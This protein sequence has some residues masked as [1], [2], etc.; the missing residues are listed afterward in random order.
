[1]RSLNNKI[2]AVALAS[3]LIVIVSSVYFIRQ[4]DGI[5]T[6]LSLPETAESETSA[7]TS[8]I[9][10]PVSTSP[11]QY[12]QRLQIG[13]I[14]SASLLM[15]TWIMGA[16]WIIR[17]FR[18]SLQNPENIVAQLVQGNTS[19]KVTTR[20][21]EFA[22]VVTGLAR[23][24]ENLKRSSDFAR[25]I[26]EGNFD[27]QFQPVS[28]LDILGN[29]LLQ[30]REKLKNIAESDKIRN[31]TTTGLAM[32][33]DLIRK[34]TDQQT[35]SD[36][37]ISQLVKYTKSNQGGLF[38]LNRDQENDPFLELIACYARPPL[39]TCVTFPRIM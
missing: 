4:L 19:V 24:S 7:V 15:L 27:F 34:S 20:D 2:I 18:T 3:I 39:S 37:L 13:S 31:W 21:D 16:F 12:R 23:L 30:M 35:L 8:K 6:Q 33:A 22:G 29:S 36:T 25:S 17:S 9:S 38:I 26:G 5:K 28:D 1:M 10:E 14:V 11:D 32:F